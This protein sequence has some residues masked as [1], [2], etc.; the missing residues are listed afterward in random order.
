MNLPH[1]QRNPTISM[2]DLERV[3]APIESATGMPNA[4]YT[5]QKYFELERDA[6]LADTW[7]AV[8]FAD[9]LQ[10]NQVR[11]LEFMGIPLFMARD[12]DGT[13]RVFHNVCSHRGMRLVD[14]ERRTNGRVVCPYHSWTYTLNG[15]LR[16]T[17]H[18]GGVGV[19]SVPGFSC[20]GRGLKPVRSHTWM[21]V[22]FINLSGEAPDFA[23]SAAP[24]IARAR[25]L[26]GDSG[27]SSL[28]LVGP[29]DQLEI[30]VNC[31]WKLAVENYLEAYHLPFIHPGL[32]SY[33]PLE[34]HI[35]EIH[36]DNF[37]GQLTRTFDPGLDAED[38][39]PLFPDWDP[40]RLAHGDYPALFPNLLLGF[41]AN[42][43]FAMIIHPLTPITCREE[44][45][46]FYAGDRAQ[47]DRFT[48]VRRRNLTTWT[49]VFNEDIEPCERMQAG[50]QSPAY[51]GG[52]FSPELDKCSHHFHQWMARRYREVLDHGA[53]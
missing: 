51:S 49:A 33:S 45:A 2:P 41:Q 34:A 10:N 22:V 21:G 17:P 4:A 20:E 6:I 44:L 7:V 11:P 32:N 43:V 5:E 37:A 26:M 8:A 40:E 23:E 3:I 1:I 46:I 38:P 15:S 14:E 50:R 31:N 39:L 28:R 47:D 52:V 9:S 24:A 16:A 25:S 48:Q 18:I 29:E 36:G 27:E 13:V 42:H 53:V 12:R 35:C 19:H 30:Q